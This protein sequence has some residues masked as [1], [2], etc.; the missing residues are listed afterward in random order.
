MQDMLRVEIRLISPIVLM[1]IVTRP[2]LMLRDVCIKCT[3]NVMV[4]RVCECM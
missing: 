2:C 3:C 1:V 4:E